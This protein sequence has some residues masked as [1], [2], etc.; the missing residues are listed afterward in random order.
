MTKDLEVDI[1]QIKHE[2]FDQGN[3]LKTLL[4]SQAQHVADG[5]VDDLV[6]DEVL[7]QLYQLVDAAHTRQQI[8]TEVIA[9]HMR[10][11]ARASLY[12][13]LTK[14][15]DLGIV[16]ETSEGYLRRTTVDDSLRISRHPQLIAAARKLKRTTW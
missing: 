2:L 13:K 12:S 15:K 7:L 10:N 14:L 16:E 9:L 1:Q 5:V 4:Y 11:G 8:V 3:M 6:A